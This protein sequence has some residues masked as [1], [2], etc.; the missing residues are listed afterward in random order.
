[1]DRDKI[2]KEIFDN[3]PLGLLNTKPS[4]SPA[5]NEDERLVASFN[6]IN[7]QKKRPG[8]RQVCKGI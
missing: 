8:L 5:Q 2:L 6:E 4:T 1:M 3:D 7:A